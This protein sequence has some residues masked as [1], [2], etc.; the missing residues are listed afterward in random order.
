LR[1]GRNGR[2]RL[3][4]NLYQRAIFVLARVVY[5][6][7]NGTLKDTGRLW[8]SSLHNFYGNRMKYDHFFT[9]SLSRRL[10]LPHAFNFSRCVMNLLHGGEAN[11][12]VNKSEGSFYNILRWKR[13]K[14]LGSRLAKVIV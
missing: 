7:A 4:R 6:N 11:L 10:D 12:L 13:D 14:K 1:G 2:D 9:Y 8:N 5:I 3:I